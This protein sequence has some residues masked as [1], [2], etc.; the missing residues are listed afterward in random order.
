MGIKK[1]QINQVQ[2]RARVG[3]IHCVLSWVQ[4]LSISTWSGNQVWVF[5]IS[6]CAVSSVGQHLIIMS[7]LSSLLNARL[8]HLNRLNQPLNFQQFTQLV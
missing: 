2:D 3:D 1:R 5:W 7:P 4:L 6:Q 8:I